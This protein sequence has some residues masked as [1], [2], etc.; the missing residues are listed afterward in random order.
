MNLA[1]RARRTVA[2]LAATAML[3][4]AAPLA[5]QEIT[6][7]HLKAARAAITALKAT[8]EFDAVLP[9]AAAAVKSDLIQ[10]NPDMVQLISATV[11]EKALALASRRADLERAAA[12]IYAKIF[13]EQQLNEISAFYT[14]ETGKKLLSDGD[15]V[16]RQ[17]LQAASIWQRAMV[18]DL[19][20][21]VGEHID[22]VLA[23]QAKPQEQPAEGQ[24]QPVNQ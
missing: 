24:Q 19:A 2:A 17:V 1:I 15:I 5:A 12:D 6:E 20:Q 10:K 22:S 4:S 3:L 21:A 8:D 18:R 14:S 16:T 7:T 11:D 9:Q 23:A 13:S